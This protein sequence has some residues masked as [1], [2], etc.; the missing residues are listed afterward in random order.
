MLFW[1][2]GQGNASCGDV[3]V[4]LQ[5][6]PRLP[7]MRFVSIEYIPRVKRRVVSEDDPDHEREMTDIECLITD[8]ALY[9]MRDSALA[10]F[11]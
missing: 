9:R 10:V 7:G 3:T 8:S 4:H 5:T 1:R 11:A 2:H 6:P